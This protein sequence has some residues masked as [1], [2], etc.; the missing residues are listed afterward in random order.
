MKV[1]VAVD[2]F[3]GCMASAEANQAVADGIRSVCESAEIIQMPVSD[4]GE[5]WVEA[6]HAA[7]GG[8]WMEVMVKD[9]LMRPIDHGLPGK[10]LVQRL[11]AISPSINY[12]H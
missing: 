2:S 11:N 5:G 12:E 1:V 4:G 10:R 7:V 8:N 3:K 9:P 6:F